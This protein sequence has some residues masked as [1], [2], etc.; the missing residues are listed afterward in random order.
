MDNSEKSNDSNATYDN[1]LS[2]KDFPLGL[3]PHEF[4]VP[5]SRWPYDQS[6]DA[7]PGGGNLYDNFFH[8][9][10][11]IGKVVPLDERENG[12][13][14]RNEIFNLIYKRAEGLVVH[15]GLGYRADCLDHKNAERFSVV[16]LGFPDLP[17]TEK[18]KK[19]VTRMMGLK[20]ED[21]LKV[22]LDM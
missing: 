8:V 12:N 22:Y 15:R 11:S 3:S 16:V 19:I 5:L 17:P 2:K 14:A 6:Y 9:L 1:G 4:C 7:L 21:L 20:E 10:E 13:T 18:Q